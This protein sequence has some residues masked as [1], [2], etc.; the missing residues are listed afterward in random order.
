MKIQSSDP[1]FDRY[2]DEILQISQCNIAK[3]PDDQAW[4]DENWQARVRVLLRL[5]YRAGA[6]AQ[7]DHSVSKRIDPVDRVRWLADNGFMAGDIIEVVREVERLRETDRSLLGSY[8]VTDGDIRSMIAEGF[9][10]AFRKAA[11]SMEAAIAWKAIRDMD[12]EEYSA[13]VD[14]VAGPLIAML[15]E[16]EKRAKT[17]K[18]E[19]PPFPLGDPELVRAMTRWAM[20]KGAIITREWFGVPPAEDTTAAQENTP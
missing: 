18:P 2:A 7:L 16:A 1:E 4:T 13:V 19:D 10:T 8:G 5:I 12:G 20:S 14:F 6:R 3:W 9:A 11:D 15:R 17:A